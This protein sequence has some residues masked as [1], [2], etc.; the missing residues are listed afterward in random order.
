MYSAVNMLADGSL[1]IAGLAREGFSVDPDPFVKIIA[2]RPGCLSIR[3]GREL[4]L[5]YERGA[6]LTG[7]EDVVFCSGPVARAL[8]ATARAADLDEDVMPDYIETARALVREM[9]SHGRGG[10]LIISTDAQPQVAEATPYKMAIDSSV[11]SLLRLARRLGR[12]KRAGDQTNE[13]GSDVS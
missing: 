1:V 9:A 2:T 4:L 13:G 7:G 8:E 3:R 12:T 10:I 5:A 6:I 11:T